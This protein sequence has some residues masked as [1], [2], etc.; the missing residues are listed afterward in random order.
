MTIFKSHDHIDDQMI[1]VIINLECTTPV[2]FAIITLIICT[3][4]KVHMRLMEMSTFLQ[5][6]HV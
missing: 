5:N 4:H 3:K 1:T 6:I 2:L